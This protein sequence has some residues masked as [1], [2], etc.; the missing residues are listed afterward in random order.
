M[1]DY[2]ENVTRCSICLEDL[3]NPKSLPCLHT[4]CLSCLEVHI[5]NKQPGDK[6]PCPLCRSVF[7]IPQR[8]LSTLQRNFFLVRLTELKNVSEQ[9]PGRALCEACED[10][11]DGTTSRVPPATTYCVDCGQRL[12]ERC[13]MP[14]RKIRTAAHRV[15][16]LNQDLETEILASRSSRC[17]HHVEERE[18][19][20]CFDC[21]ENI[22]LMCFAVKHQQHKCQEI[23]MAAESFKSQLATE[24]SKISARIGKLRQLLAK[25]ESARDAFLNEVKSLQRVIQ[26]RGEE[27]KQAVD[28]CVDAA[29]RDMELVKME[30]EKIID[31]EKDRF[32]LSLVAM[33][34]FNAYAS[35][36]QKRG[37]SEDISRA[38]KDLFR[39]AKELLQNDAHVTAS[40]APHI[41]VTPVHCDMQR[42]IA[43]LVGSLITTKSTGALRTHS[44]ESFTML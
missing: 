35:E 5:G 2:V 32:Q 38:A 8:G 6:V 28:S 36:L 44:F 42:C 1:R 13:S 16:L 12:C 9:L 41:T 30:S 40:K 3:N 14:H 15:V 4:F 18:K 22:C 7:K 25:T 11:S 31:T 19:L 21:A 24:I 27:I 17:S 23:E 29:V 43:N 26:Q 37:K 34:S 20:Y 10:E 39:R 33:E